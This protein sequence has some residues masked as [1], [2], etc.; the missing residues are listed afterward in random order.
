MFMLFEVGRRRTLR[1]QLTIMDF[2]PHPLITQDPSDVDSIEEL[3]TLDGPEFAGLILEVFAMRA[4]TPRWALYFKGFCDVVR[5]RLNEPIVA[6]S[7]SAILT[8]PPEA[9]HEADSVAAAMDCLHDLSEDEL[10]PF[11]PDLLTLSESNNP[12]AVTLSKQAKDTILFMDDRTTVWVPDHKFDTMAIRTLQERVHT[13]E[14]MRPYLHDLLCWLQDPNW[15]PYPACVKQLARFP[16]PAADAI[17]AAMKG[18][19]GDGMW[20]VHM[21]RFMENHVPMEYWE[22]VYPQIKELVTKPVGDEAESVVAEC[23][24]G[25]IATFEIWKGDQEE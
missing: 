22:V 24:A 2:P 19:R 12:L 18:N 6:S 8:L 7:L 11:R 13:A 9:E 15:P 1:L 25:W 4:G 21:I 16:E 5:Q 23:C 14:E 20:V 3:R 10:L 17:R